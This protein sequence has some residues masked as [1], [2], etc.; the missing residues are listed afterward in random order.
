MY[1]LY[2]LWHITIIGTYDT[3]PKIDDKNGIA[4]RLQDKF[5]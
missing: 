2:I 1:N 5:K 4:K 3:Y